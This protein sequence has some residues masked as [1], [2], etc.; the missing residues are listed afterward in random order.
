MSNPD[1]SVPVLLDILSYQVKLTPHPFMHL[2]L[3]NEE[4]IP[5]DSE[6]VKHDATWHIY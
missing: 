6:P 3:M 5:G 4:E 1:V 2:L